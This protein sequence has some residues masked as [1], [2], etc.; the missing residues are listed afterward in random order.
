MEALFNAEISQKWHMRVTRINWHI[1]FIIEH[2]LS[3]YVYCTFTFCV[4]LP[5]LIPSAVTVTSNS[6][7]PAVE[8]PL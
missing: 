7:S 1:S 4:K 3:K 5:T 8:M 6:K 2:D